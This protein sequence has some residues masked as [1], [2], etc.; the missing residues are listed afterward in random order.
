MEVRSLE[1][2]KFVCWKRR[3]C[4]AYHAQQRRSRTASR[5]YTRRHSSWHTTRQLME[6]QRLTISGLRKPVLPSEADAFAGS[7]QYA[8]DLGDPAG[9]EST[10]WIVVGNGIVRQLAKSRCQNSV[11][12]DRL[13]RQGNGYAPYSNVSAALK[14]KLRASHLTTGEYSSLRAGAGNRDTI[15]YHFKASAIVQ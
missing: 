11:G 12:W 14:W 9:S 8:S 15:E 2:S 7:R 5:S 3:K 10:A 13:I 1:N 4:N 6:R